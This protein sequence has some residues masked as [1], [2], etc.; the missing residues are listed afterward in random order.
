M[1]NRI[2]IIIFFIFVILLLTLNSNIE[3]LFRNNKVNNEINN[4]I[5][6]KVNNVVND[7]NNIWM[8]WENKKNTTKPIY[9]DICYDTIM[10]HCKDDFNIYLLNEKTILKFI[11]DL[12][13]DL[14]KK[15]SIQQKSDYIRYILLYK[16]GGIWIDSD[17]I[18]LKNLI[19]IIKKLKI[20]NFIGFG[21]HYGDI[22]CKKAISGKPFPS[23]WIMASRKNDILMHR[24]YLK[25]DDL[26]DHNYI[27]IK[28][29][30]FSIGRELMWKEIQYLYKHHSDW[31]YYHYS[32]ICLERDSKGNKLRNYRM[33]SDENID[34]HC[35]NKFI[36][37]PIYNTSPGFPKWFLKLNKEQLL[38]S[39]MLISKL[40]RLSLNYNSSKSFSIE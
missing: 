37:I 10:K 19:T 9:L 28:K 3:H 11:P 23:N 26:L 32:S 6:N 27:N 16:Y 13:R 14:N 25:C 8:Y 22:K 12:R 31:K 4:E 33:I 34:E 36:C 29:N 24:C 40:F 21:C 18:V 7:S 15:L 5:N 30:Y 39:N 1:K 35:K 38:K 20:Y 2:Y 17:T